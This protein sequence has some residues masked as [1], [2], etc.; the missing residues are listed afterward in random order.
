MIKR[1]ILVAVIGYIIGILWGLYLKFSIVLFYI[2]TFATYYIYI[3]FFKNKKKNKFRLLSFNRYIRYLKLVINKA[4]IIIIVLFSIISNAIV[5]YQNNK[6]KT[7]YQDGENIEIIGVVASSKIEKQY[8]N[9]YIAKILNSQFNIYIQVNKKE[10]LEYGDKIIIKGKYSG[11]SEQRNYN[12][13]DES[14]YLKT[15]KIIGRLRA[16]NI[17]LIA[18]NQINII[19]RLANRAKLSIKEKIDKIFEGKNSAMLKGL[20][21]GDKQEIED[22]VREKF[23]TLNISHILAISGM[24]IGYIIIGIQLLLKKIIGK[25]NT[26]IAT[27][28][29]LIIYIFITGFSP[30]VIRATVM[31]I[32]VISSTLFHKKNDIWNAMSISLLGILI[33]NPFLITDIGLQ[34]SYL[35]TI[36]IILFHSTVLQFFNRVKFK[37]NSKII[38]YIKEVLSVT[39]SAQIMIYPIL[40]F[41]YNIIGLYSLIANL[42]IS[43]IIG[44]IIIFAFITI[45]ISF[46]FNPI[47]KLFSSLLNIGLEI[48]NL[49]S[50]ISKFPFAKIYIKTPSIY[51]IILYYI[52][53][54]ALLYLYK[55]YTINA[56]TITQKRIRNLI[57]LLKYEFNKKKKRYFK[58]IVLI[59]II[60]ICFHVTPKNLKIYFVDVGQGD[61]TFIVTPKNKTILIDG[62][63]SIASEFDVGKNTLIPYLLDRGYTRN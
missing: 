26:K 6:Y 17:E 28:I 18:K 27:I 30:S 41:N 29:I 22:D 48:L 14:E 42:F 1:P 15:K 12:G 36:G 59:L 47:A 44:I 5:Y 21:L 33:Y 40:L 57:A 20:L 32:L 13:Y 56:L 39:I 19:L 31:A 46:I 10:E 11:P 55:I 9:L 53:I 60:L 2:L 7:T 54:F 43:I 38:E 4:T 35:G 49:I 3:V 23:Q 63:G 50:N 24:H 25:K 52:I 62:G 8:Y 16:N 61:C 58:Y 37:R 51:S 34:L 45:I